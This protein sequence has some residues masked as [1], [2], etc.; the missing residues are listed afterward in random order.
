V[1]R[2]EWRFPEPGIRQREGLQL[3]PQLYSE[4]SKASLPKV[5]GAR[6]GL[7]VTLLS[8]R[9]SKGIIAAERACKWLSAVI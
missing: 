2:S 3:R 8:Y 9:K 4:S 1:E 5:G 6:K 7:A